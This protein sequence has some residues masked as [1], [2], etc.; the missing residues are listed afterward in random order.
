M[1]SLLCCGV[2]GKLRCSGGSSAHV[3]ESVQ[4]RDTR[5]QHGPRLF[6]GRHDAHRQGNHAPPTEREGR[7]LTVLSFASYCA[8][9]VFFRSILCSIVFCHLLLNR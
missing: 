7:G 8:S 6:Q 9:C 1:V 3:H 5:R 2:G 4:R